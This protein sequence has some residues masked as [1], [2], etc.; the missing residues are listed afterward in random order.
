MT[1]FN[2]SFRLFH[3]YQYTRRLATL[4]SLAT[5]PDINI[6]LC[7]SVY[8]W[9]NTRH[10]HAPLRICTALMDGN[11][12][13][14]GIDQNMCARLVHTHGGFTTNA[15]SYDTC[16]KTFN[17]FSYRLIRISLPLS[18]TKTLTQTSYFITNLYTV[19]AAVKRPRDFDWLSR[20]AS[21]HLK[22]TTIAGI[23]IFMYI[24]RTKGCPTISFIVLLLYAYILS[25]Q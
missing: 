24:R 23:L 7:T 10:P 16:A 5:T 13:Q 20:F 25:T 8:R 15:V 9:L 19:A 22:R 1:F 2:F 6:Y 12:H 14:D 3:I 21:S 18:R 17:V 4:F 11:P